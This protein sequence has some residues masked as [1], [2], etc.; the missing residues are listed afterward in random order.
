VGGFV[1]RI[2]G[3]CLPGRAGHGGTRAAGALLATGLLV[4]SFGSA[5]MAA[6]ARPQV[7]AV[8]GSLGGV[9]CAGVSCV[10]V[11]GRSGTSTGTLAEKLNGTKWSVVTSPNPK[12][13]T[14]ASLAGVAC[15][16][17]K[18]CLAVGRYFV[19]G[20][21]LPTAEMWNGTKWSLLTVPA[22]SGTT[23]ASLGAVACVSST[24]C[25]AVGE[26]GDNTLAESWN[27]AKWSIV[28]SPSPNPA[29]PEVLSGVACPSA[30][31]C[32]AVGYYFPSNDAGS[33][34]EKWD[35]SKW[36]VVKTPTS[37]SGQLIGDG[38]FSASACM[39]V[40]I[41]NNL[42]AIAQAWKGSAWSATTPAEPSGATDSQ[43]NGVSCPASSSCVAVGSYFNSSV[44]ATL[45]ED[46]NGTKWAVQSMP[47]ISG[48]TYAS[49]ANIACPAKTACWAAGEAIA[50]SATTPVI[51]RWNGK[52]WSLAVS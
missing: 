15:T 23:N 20:K 9:A 10:A 26:S 40:G 14:G 8:T 46:W 22:P 29:K 51:E 17:T 13:S 41:G 52:S 32:W 31:D 44:T 11:G 36:S 30:K 49:L 24:N 6:T 18:N 19:P 50:G 37:K 25:Q 42:F 33:L 4:A 1:V 38:C 21:T 39:S 7:A 48:S 45:G 43:L 27:G 5:A 3:F 47:A 35:G 34:T 28:S 16:S 12:G 2:F